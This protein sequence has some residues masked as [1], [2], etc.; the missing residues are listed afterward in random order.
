MLGEEAAS[1]A[2]ARNDLDDA[3]RE[4]RFDGEGRNV[5][6]LFHGYARR[7]GFE[8]DGGGGA[9]KVSAERRCSLSGR[10][11]EERREQQ[12]STYT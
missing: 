11:A 3:R 8:A 1:V 6:G 2:S 9:G 4:A 12:K 7:R 5:E 10:G